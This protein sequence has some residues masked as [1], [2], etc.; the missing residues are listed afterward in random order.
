M[1]DNVI[2]F[3]T[4]KAEPREELPVSEDLVALIESLLESAKSGHT[5]GLVMV[6]ISNE[7]HAMSAMHIPVYSDSSH[8]ATAVS[9]LTGTIDRVKHRIYDEFTDVD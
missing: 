1:A 9:V 7:G 8:T 5:V 6:G 2:D 3:G 4:R